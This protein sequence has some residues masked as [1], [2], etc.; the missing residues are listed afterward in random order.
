[1]LGDNVAVLAANK[2]QSV[3]VTAALAD[4]VL[5]VSK[6]VLAADK[7]L[8]VS[9]TALAANKVLSVAETIAATNKVL[10]VSVA[11]ALAD[12]VLSVAETALAANKVLS[13]AVAVAVANIET[14]RAVGP[15]VLL[16]L[17]RLEIRC[18]AALLLAGLEM[19]V[20]GLS[21]EIVEAVAVEVAIDIEWCASSA[22][23]LH[24]LLG[25]AVVEIAGHQEW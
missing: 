1:L 7:V 23:R 8:G 18:G 24:A 17:S 20:D 15:A 2:I 14:V 11:A 4:P 12:P 6:T 9:K 21:L 13:V 19:V 22:F 25:A 10:S 16:G 5:G 3:S